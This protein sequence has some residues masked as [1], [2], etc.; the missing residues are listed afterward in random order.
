MASHKSNK[1]KCSLLPFKL[2]HVVSIQEAKQ[3][4]GWQI[5]AFNLPDVWKISQGEGVKI[6]V[7]D[8][9]VDLNHPDLKD[10]LLPGMNFINKNKKP[11]DD[12]SH[13]S[14]C[15]GI[16]VAENNAIGVVGV[17]PKAKVI[18]VKVLDK[19]G[20]GNLEDVANG[21]RWA[22]DNKADFVTMSLGSPVPL[23]IL[24]R[25]IN[26]AEKKGTICICAA[27]NCGP[28]DAIF[29]PANY[30]NTI[31]VGSINANLTRS[32]FS[33]TGN[34]DFMAPGNDILS[35]VPPNWYGVMSG[36][37][38]AAPFVAGICALLLSWVR[39]NKTNIQLKTAQD[40]KKILKTNTIPIKG[41]NRAFLQGFGIIE[42][43]KLLEW[44]RS[45][46]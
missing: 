25:A 7:L 14:H 30:K 26:Y 11:Q 16:M 5:S 12:C 24:E 41:D 15:S 6:A 13:G 18:P 37:S 20:N 33:A 45:S 8:S 9:G 31:A 17:A 10:N 19:K 4:S 3:R 29:Y 40:Y 22:T 23:P 36:T 38:Q 44:L 1:H 2:E 34:L 32:D 42:P 46:K 27:G 21:I 35:T 28:S 43:I 39:N